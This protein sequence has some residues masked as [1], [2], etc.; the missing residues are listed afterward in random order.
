MT[1]TFR[2]LPDRGL[3]VVR[4]TGHATLDE[5]VVASNAYLEHADF[6]LGQKQLVDL[7]HITG[8]EKDYVRFMNMQAEK[9]ARLACAGVQSLAV[10]IAPT[11]VSRDLSAMFVRSWAD[12]DAVVLLVQHTEAEALALLGQPE[13]SIDMLLATFVK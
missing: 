9:A 8:F 11:P 6:A 13:D 12:T 4:Y 3:V 5:T 10:Y 2:I 7:T 1:V